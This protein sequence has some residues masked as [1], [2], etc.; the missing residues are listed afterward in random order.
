MKPS[1]ETP[2]ANEF[3][4]MRAYLAQQGFTQ[5]WID[6]TVGATPDGRTRS[7]IATEL[8]AGLKVLPQK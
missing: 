1:D 4:Q 8:R 7:E 2:P 6:S 5:A 3:G